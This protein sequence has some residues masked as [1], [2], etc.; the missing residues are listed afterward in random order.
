MLP[1]FTVFDNHST[2]EET[3]DLIRDFPTVVRSDRNVG[4][5]SAID[6]W[7]ESLRAHPPDYVYVIES[8]MIHYDLAH[9]RACVG[10]LD[11]HPEFG[12]MR[13]HEYSV[14]DWRLYNKD[15]PLPNSRR[16]LWQSHRNKV[17][18][19]PITHQCVIEPFYST[20]F[21]TQLPAL[22]RYDTMREV[23]DSLRDRSTFTELDFQ[24]LYHA[25]HPRTAI[26][27][28]GIFHCDLNP[29][30]TS[31]ITGSWTDPATLRR[32]GYSNTR[33]SSI[34]PVSEYTVAVLT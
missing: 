12:S 23:F 8:D 18:G 33:H 17:T 31:A 24:T 34:T 13:L 5:W 10:F 4:Y 1:N 6:W 32:L 29:Y 2:V 15:V 11:D 7:L 19:E 22:N 16:N 21:L 25:R 28:G 3:L 9:V 27:D 14:A 26:T 20:N 30:G